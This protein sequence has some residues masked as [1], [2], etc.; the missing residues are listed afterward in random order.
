[1]VRMRFPLV[2]VISAIA[3]WGPSAEAEIRIAVA[4]DMTGANA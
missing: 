2:A 1:M 3:L 4:G